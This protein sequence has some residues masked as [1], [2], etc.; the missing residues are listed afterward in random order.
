MSGRISYYGGIVTNGLVLN[1][2]AAKKDSYAGS[3]TVW[4]DISGTTITGSLV[5][6]SSYNPANGGSIVFDGTDDYVNI[7]SSGY[8][9][10]V[11]FT[12]QVWTKITRFGG[13]PFNGSENRATLSSN[14]YPYTTNQ[15]FL[16]MATSQAA[17]SPFSPTPGRETFFISIGTDQFI[18][19]ASIGSLTTFVNNWVQ[20]S[21]VVNGTNLIRLYINGIEPTYSNQNNGPSSLLYTGGPFSL[22][23]RNNIREFLQG[24]ISQTLIYNR[25]LTA[26]EVLQNYNATKTRFGL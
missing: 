22:G 3:G 11:N 18:A 5:S 4:R 12:L 14:S 2:D 9:L 19:V 1:L 25:A 26:S 21:A 8:D 7:S 17:G 24:S 16:L 13:G 15:G 6:G 23:S 10:G 20:L